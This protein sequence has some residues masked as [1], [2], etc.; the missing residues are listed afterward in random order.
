[1]S[2]T[3]KI[4]MIYGASIVALGLA[5]LVVSGAIIAVD[6]APAA[7]HGLVQAGSETW[8]WFLALS[9]AGKCLVITWIGAC[10]CAACLARAV[11]NPVLALA[12]PMWGA[13][14]LMVMALPSD[15][16][17]V[18]CC[19]TI[20]LRPDASAAPLSA[21]WIVSDILVS[22]AAI[23]TFVGVGCWAVSSLDSETPTE[24]KPQA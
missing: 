14:I 16:G 9:F 10:L 2:R 5:G 11:V 21:A 15:P 23:M 20:A 12:A 13:V 19:G 7:W 4:C 3:S 6:S 1:M 8:A 22:A 18:W 24:R 17:Q